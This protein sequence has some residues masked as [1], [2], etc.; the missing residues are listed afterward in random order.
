MSLK[1]SLSHAD[2]VHLVSRVAKA[3]K[4]NKTVS[5]G[6][7]GAVL[8]VKSAKSGRSVAVVIVELGEFF[9]GVHYCAVTPEGAGR[10]LLHSHNIGARTTIERLA[11]TAWGN[12]LCQP[13]SEQYTDPDEGLGVWLSDCIDLRLRRVAKAAV[14]LCA[15]HNGKD[16]E[17]TLA[18]IAEQLGVTFSDDTF[19]AFITD[20]ELINQHR[21]SYRE[22][23]DDSFVEPAKECIPVEI[24]PSDAQSHAA[25]LEQFHSVD[26][27]QP[28]RP[29]E[30]KARLEIW[31]VIA[32]TLSYVSMPGLVAL[33]N[34]ALH[35]DDWNRFLQKAADLETLNKMQPMRK[36]NA[37]IDLLSTTLDRDS[38]KQLVLNTKNTFNP[39]DYS[40]FKDW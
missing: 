26:Y 34:L 17:P 8:T 22:F 40:V 37:I 10:V 15:L 13:F 33:F 25:R 29:D 3:L 9:N 31:D 30:D 7:S 23:L 36:R 6:S 35:S 16:P 32:D 20:P 18:R 4:G 12:N 19:N 2:A 1:L 28:L 39:D 21:D 14:S 11:A 38:L 5:Y 24:G 27:E